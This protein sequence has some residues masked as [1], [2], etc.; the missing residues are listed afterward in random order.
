MG[1]VPAL[2]T[3]GNPCASHCQE[4]IFNPQAIENKIESRKDKTES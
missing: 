3:V 2:R 1:D 4:R